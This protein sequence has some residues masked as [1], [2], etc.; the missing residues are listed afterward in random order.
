MVTMWK[1]IAPDDEEHELIIEKDEIEKIDLDMT[2]SQYL[3]Q[4]GC[5]KANRLALAKRKVKEVI[6][7]STEIGW[8]IKYLCERNYY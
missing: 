8:S 2:V 4:E 6:Y 7:T 1:N 5:K 3:M